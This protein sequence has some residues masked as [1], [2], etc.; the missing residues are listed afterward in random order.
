[1]A[2]EAREGPEESVDAR[3]AC[4]ASRSIKLLLFLFLSFSFIL[5][6][7][8]LYLFV[9]LIFIIFTEIKN[10]GR[11]AR[12]GRREGLKAETAKHPIVRMT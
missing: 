3:R 10:G 5:F 6:T 1:M 12:E 7:F 9:I 2:G 11:E 4:Q 8:L